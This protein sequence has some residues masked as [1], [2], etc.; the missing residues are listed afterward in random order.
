MTIDLNAVEEL[1]EMISLLVLGVISSV[2]VAVI[3]LCWE[4][5]QI[6][7]FAKAVPKVTVQ[8][9]E[10][11]EPVVTRPMPFEPLIEG[12]V[13][14][15]VALTVSIVVLVETMPPLKVAMPPTIKAFAWVSVV[16]EIESVEDPFSPLPAEAFQ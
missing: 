4:T 12:L 3:V 8:V 16:P 6:G 11:L 13:P 15:V 9:L 5:V 14:H 7:V 1:I 2:V 10:A